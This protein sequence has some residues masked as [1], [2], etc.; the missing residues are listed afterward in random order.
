MKISK[1]DTLLLFRLQKNFLLQVKKKSLFIQ[2]Y[3]LF[4]SKLAKTDCE[5][6][7]ERK[8][9]ESLKRQRREVCK[10]GRVGGRKESKKERKEVGREE[11]RMRRSGHRS[12]RK[13]KPVRKTVFG[14]QG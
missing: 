11:G 8:G 12:G 6:R 13:M 7:E 14:P 4:S 2:K 1:Q 5:E 10:E 9:R 3:L